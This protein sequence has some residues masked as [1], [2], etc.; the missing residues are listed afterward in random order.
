MDLGIFDNHHQLILTEMNRII[1]IS[2]KYLHRAA[3]V[4]S[5]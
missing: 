2:P 3:H 1:V 5:R 4:V